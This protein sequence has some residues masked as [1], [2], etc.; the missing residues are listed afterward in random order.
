MSKLLMVEL[1]FSVTASNTI[2]ELNLYRPGRNRLAARS[3]L[4]NATFDPLSDRA[5][6]AGEFVI[7]NCTF[8]DISTTPGEAPF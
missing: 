1:L 4:I 2:F 7:E 5:I 6:D 8:D 3:T